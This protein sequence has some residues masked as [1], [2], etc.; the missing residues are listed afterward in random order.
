[1]LHRKILCWL[2]V[3][4]I[5]STTIA[6]SV[7]APAD[8]TNGQAQPGVADAELVN[9]KSLSQV[10]ITP[11]SSPLTP[12][13]PRLRIGETVFAAE[14]ATTSA[15][16][17]IGLSGRDELERMTGMLFVSDVDKRFSFWMKGMKFPLDFIWISGECTVADIT[18]D[19]P[20]LEAEA[21]AIPVYS[22]QAPAVYNFEI[23]GGEA[24]LHGIEV[25]DKAQFLWMPENLAGVCQ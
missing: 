10:V 2:G 13:T 12:T 24:H 15:Q 1:M 16:K 25:G 20:V 9:R 6:C 14:L 3:I 11:T 5:C 8:G 22:A 7:L 19:V 21:G 17:I 18:K 23:N 4:V